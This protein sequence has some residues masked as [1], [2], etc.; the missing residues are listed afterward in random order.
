MF[1]KKLS[2]H[3][4]ACKF[5]E[6]CKFLAKGICAFKHGLS[7]KSD[8]NIEDLKKQIESLKEENEAKQLEQK[9]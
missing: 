1:K 7:D 6:D 3:P 4:K 2:R 5:K 9:E 8:A